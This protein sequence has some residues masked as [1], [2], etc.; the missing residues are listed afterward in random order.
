MGNPQL[1]AYWM[2]GKAI[3]IDSN[4]VEENNIYRI[5]PSKSN[6]VIC[7]NGNKYLHRVPIVGELSSERVIVIV[8]GELTTSEFNLSQRITDELYI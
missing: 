4:N 5:I 8:R 1:R 2:I 6:T 3:I 7:I